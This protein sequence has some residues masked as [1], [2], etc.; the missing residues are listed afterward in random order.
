MTSP[1]A[2][3]PGAGLWRISA[4]ADATL[5]DALESVLG[6]G[7]LSVSRFEEKADGSGAPPLWRVLALVDVAPDASALA[8]AVAATAGLPRD[9]L[10]AIEVEAL[11]DEDWLALNRRQFP[12][13]EAGRFFIHGSHFDGVPPAGKIALRLD[14]GP[15]FG[16]GTHETTRG[17][18]IAIDE[19]M[20][21]FAKAGRP[22]RALDVG[23][24]SGILALAIAAAAGDESAFPVVATDIDP[25]AAATTRENAAANGLAERVVTLAG[26]GVSGAEVVA[27]AP[28]DLIVANILAEPLVALAPALAELLASGGCLVLSGLLTVQEGEVLAAYSAAGLTLRRTIVL[29]DWSTMVLCEG[30]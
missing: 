7:G 16:S 23:C 3:S 14:A 29:G 20:T 9:S 5:A 21:V 8:D 13:V 1:G 19:T 11:P 4:V 30:G 12:P 6:E 17:S 10:P 28:Y 25:I 18:L 26:E 15:A 27:G 2:T 22:V 24:G